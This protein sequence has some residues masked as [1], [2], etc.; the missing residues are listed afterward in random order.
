MKYLVYLFSSVNIYAGVRFLLNTVGILQT[1]KY[2]HGSNIFFAITLTTAGLL[3]M[4]FSISRTDHSF[5][6]LIDAA[7]WI[8]TLILLI[9]NMLFADYK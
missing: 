2:G 7:P 4:Y 6:L 5:A 1:S 9:V 8:L 3:A